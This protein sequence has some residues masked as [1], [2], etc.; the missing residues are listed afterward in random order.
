MVAV[1]EYEDD[2]GQPEAWHGEQ[3]AT[4]HAGLGAGK[5]DILDDRMK[6]RLKVTVGLILHFG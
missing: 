2:A 5:A 4:D 3:E 1:M 6:A